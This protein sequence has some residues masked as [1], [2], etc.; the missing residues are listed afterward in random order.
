MQL[1]GTNYF[2]KRGGWPAWMVLRVSRPTWRTAI[3]VN[4]PGQQEESA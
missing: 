4:H 2:D 1:T 3:K